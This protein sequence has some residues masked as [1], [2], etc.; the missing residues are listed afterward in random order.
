MKKGEREKKKERYF[1]A[2]S[3]LSIKFGA[4]I[5]LPDV[6]DAHM[7]ENPRT[8]TCVLPFILGELATQYYHR[9]RNE[10]YTI[11]GRKYFSTRE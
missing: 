11:Y 5:L 1:I 10:F 9:L 8:L 7:V 3:V 4:K 6:R 2:A